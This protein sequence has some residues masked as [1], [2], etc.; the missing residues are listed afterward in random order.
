MSNQRLQ[1]PRK[2]TS[3]PDLQ[4]VTVVVGTDQDRQ[5]LNSTVER[6]EAAGALVYRTIS[7]AVRHLVE[8][9]ARPVSPLPSP[10]AQEAINAPVAVLNVGLESFYHDLIEQQVPAI[11]VDW[12][13]PAGGN[14]TLM[15]LLERM[16]T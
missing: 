4:I 5:D 14:E 1:G 16:G 15:A 3:R 10:V 12:R 9:H 8:R 6:L 13:P 2:A 11:Q 7:E